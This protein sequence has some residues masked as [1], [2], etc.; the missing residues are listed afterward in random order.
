MNRRRDL[1]FVFFCSTLGLMFLPVNLLGLEL[2]PLMGLVWSVSGFR[3][4]MAYF[5]LYFLARPQNIQNAF[6]LSQMAPTFLSM[7]EQ[8]SHVTPPPFI[9]G[10]YSPTGIILVGIG[11]VF[12]DC[13]VMAWIFK[14]MIQRR[15]MKR[16]LRISFT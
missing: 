3:Y 15:L 2:G 5:G 12:L 13:L 11:G 9:L 14:R 6:Q 16:G 4:A 7:E 8:L 1:R 10:F